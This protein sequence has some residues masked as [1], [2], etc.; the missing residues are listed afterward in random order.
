MIIFHRIR[1]DNVQYQKCIFEDL[2]ETDN[3]KQLALTKKCMTILRS[4]VELAD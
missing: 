1:R 2:V 3:D 4:V